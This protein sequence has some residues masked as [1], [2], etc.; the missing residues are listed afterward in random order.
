MVF[1]YAQTNKTV[2]IGVLTDKSTARTQVLFQQMKKEI[3]AVIG[4]DVTVRFKQPLENQFNF[5]EAKKNYEKMVAGDA[6]IILAF[7]VV[8]NLVINKIKQ[9]AKPTI[10]F[11]SVNSDFTD[12]PKEQK[13]S[14]I[15]NITYLITPFSYT[16][17]LEAFHS[18]YE[19][20]HVGIIVDE[21]LPEILPLQSLFDTHFSDKEAT[22]S[23]LPIKEGKL[24]PSSLNEVDAVYLISGFYLQ[25]TQFG[26]LVTTINK[27]KIPSFSANS[28][29][30]VERGI[31]ATNQ[32]ETNIDRFFR[33]I[34]LNVESIISGVNPS[35]LPIFVDYKNKLTV[36]YRTA[37]EIGFPMR[38]SML[39]SVDFVEGS[40]EIHPGPNQKSY[41][42]TDILNGV[43]EKNLS[44][45]AARKEVALSEQDVKLAKSNFLPNV[46]ASASGAYV[47]PE[48]AKVSNG[49]RPELS[50]SANIGLEQV[51]YSEGANANIKIQKNLQ[52]AQQEV[53]NAEELDA[54][55][56]ASASYFNALILKT[57]V[58]IQNQNL[59]VTKK[60]L[61]IAQQNFETGASG[62]SDV[63]RLQS[64]L[65]QNT[66]SLINAGNSLQQAFNAI[67][68]LMNNPM[69]TKIDVMDAGIAN[70]IF[71][72]YRY[73]EF[74][75]ILDSPQLRPA[76][77]EFLI[78]EA[79]TNSPELKN[80]G[81]NLDATQINYKL[82]NLG[83]LIPTVALQGNYNMTFSRS[84]EGAS[85]PAG[86]PMLPD[87]YYN[88]G[89]NISLP[90]FQRNE[91]NIN[92]Q[93]AK[94]QEDQ[95]L[96]QKDNIT[97][98]LDKRLNDMVL[99]VI[100]QIANIEISK[101]A[102]RTAEE[103]LSLSQNAYK[104]GAIPIIQ[105]IDAQNNL[106][107]SQLASATAVYNYLMTTMQL[108]R[109]IGYFFLMNTDERNQEFIQKA[110]QFILNKN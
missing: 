21:F 74:Q 108:E 78:E 43:V 89:L 50:T 100:N 34:A 20:D 13:T 29:A 6:D 28:I 76:F 31:L 91:R 65:A 44:L 23:L 93:I 106:L 22:Y 99:N 49:Q 37:D 11:G 68:Q 64:Q 58:R 24:T 72:N 84:G 17:D 10:L 48:L 57:N 80:L 41:T 109:V 79:K 32:P 27:N 98:D 83:R 46:V 59:Q 101:E 38:Y 8:N 61:Q 39:S 25:E 87:N 18:L 51:I 36:N 54:I 7:G 4:Q 104:Q 88:I 26:E 40:Q 77:I 96:I 45:E 82:N 35:D 9:Y 94:I 42:I 81:Y 71:K 30:D 16:K 67:N 69:S 62:K 85:P 14:E 73:E 110:N 105:L 70:G 97:L 15:P 63:L 56:N 55:L 52:K 95:L 86:F 12:F 90:I 102:E 5:P 3:T 92:K 19:Y 103:S 60:N 53:Y 75:E 66:Q 2:T 1:G 33:R 107:Q 47:D